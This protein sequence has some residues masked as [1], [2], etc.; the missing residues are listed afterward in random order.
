MSNYTIRLCAVLLIF[1]IMFSSCD[2][3]IDGHEVDSTG[4]VNSNVTVLSETE[5][6]LP[7]TTVNSSVKPH[8]KVPSV[9][10][11]T[12]HGIRFKVEFDFEEY[13]IPDSEP[14]NIRVMISYTNLSNKTISFDAGQPSASGVFERNDGVR[15]YPKESDRHDI[16]EKDKE[17]AVTISPRD[18]HYDYVYFSV[19]DFFNLE[20]TY[21]FSVEV[22][23]DQAKTCGVT[24]P[25]EI[26]EKEVK[27]DLYQG[28][29]YL[30][31]WGYRLEYI[32]EDPG[33]YIKLPSVYEES[34]EGAH[35]KVEFFSDTYLLNSYIQCRVSV[36]NNTGENVKVRQK[37]LFN[38]G[39]FV[40]DSKRDEIIPYSY[41]KER[42]GYYTDDHGGYADV[43][44]GET[45]VIE[46]VFVARVNAFS[47]EHEYAF[48][49]EFSPIFENGEKETY[50]IT[51]PVEFYSN[52]SE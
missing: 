7:E 14:L 41:C 30:S 25:I 4:T 15:A 48:I 26:I 9:Y 46:S 19:Q 40:R 47:E 22:E 44:A 3:I 33:G 11:E 27:P 50:S 12:S 18:K 52:K 17:Y 43:A 37:E 45:I 8:V 1:L 13:A 32:E 38:H 24:I 5:P 10:E 42:H 28:P 39:A 51:V 36:T 29:W 6:I 20:N 35:F 23:T 31:D 21:T 34:V 16:F 2:A 49:V